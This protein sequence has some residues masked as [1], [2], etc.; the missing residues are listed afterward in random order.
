MAIVCALLFWR[1]HIYPPQGKKNQ[2]N[3]E[4]KIEGF[5]NINLEFPATV[6]RVQEND[7]VYII[8]LNAT[9]PVV[10]MGT[11]NGDGRYY[12]QTGGTRF[13]PVLENMVYIYPAVD[14]YGDKLLVM[15][16]SRRTSNDII[17]YLSVNGI[18]IYLKSDGKLYDF[19]LTTELSTEFQN[20]NESIMQ[21]D[22]RNNTNEIW[23]LSNY[24][25]V[26]TWRVDAPGPVT[27]EYVVVTDKD[28][29]DRIVKICGDILAPDLHMLSQKGKVYVGGDVMP[30][31]EDVIDIRRYA[32]YYMYMKKNYNIYS[33]FSTTPI[34]PSELTPPIV[35]TYNVWTLT[36]INNECVFVYVGNVG[37]GIP[38]LYKVTNTGG[39][40][41]GTGTSIGSDLQIDFVNV[42]SIV[43][44][45]NGDVAFIASTEHICNDTCTAIEYNS[46]GSSICPLCVECPPNQ[47]GDPSNPEGCSNC[48]AQQVRA[49]RGSVC[50]YCPQNTEI[51]P[52]SITPSTPST[53]SPTS[54]CTGC[55]DGYIRMSNSDLPCQP[56]C[57]LYFG[58]VQGIITVNS[59]ASRVTNTDGVIYSNFGKAF[60]LNDLNTHTIN[61]GLH[62]SDYGI[63]PSS[64]TGV[65]G[66]Q[67]FNGDHGIVNEITNTNL[68]KYKKGDVAKQLY[69]G[70]HSNCGVY[71]YSG[72]NISG[73][74][75]K[76]VKSM[77]IESPSSTTTNKMK[78]MGWGHWNRAYHAAEEIQSVCFYDATAPPTDSILGENRCPRSATDQWE[79]GH[80]I[81]CP[82]GLNLINVGNYIYHYCST[83][84]PN[85]SP[86]T[87]G[88][89]CSG[90]VCANVGILHNYKS[91]FSSDCEAQAEC[92]SRGGLY[93]SPDKTCYRKFSGT[94]APCSFDAQCAGGE[95]L[96]RFGK[97]A[98]EDQAYDMCWGKGDCKGGSVYRSSKPKKCKDEH[99]IR[100]ENRDV[101]KATFGNGPSTQ[102]YRN[103]KGLEEKYTRNSKPNATVC[104]S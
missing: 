94:G 30:V 92:I 64:L 19:E 80:D 18:D 17:Q 76:T 2:I 98:N 87:A 11:I 34:V 63:V 65:N 95:I 21:I 1:K 55:P 86:C 59:P 22:Y 97:C 72:Q 53:P 78:H 7:F 91:C 4:K 47:I 42:R 33:S 56:D 32:G 84:L 40:W 48:P 74:W 26:Y 29:D 39:S 73:N 3:I 57:R 16:E 27:E 66:Q 99:Y 5:E 43:T 90:G 49:S 69:V 52:Q 8:D 46:A 45:R 70:G 77:V 23:L 61:E 79:D 9:T 50:T 20:Y 100:W 88:S 89:E 62:S 102:P 51:T 38:T 54:V 75:A 36:L 31:G 104:V 85:N 103:T 93:H 12:R 28:V 35:N 67:V 44:L 15:D 37:A 60:N 14:T 71:V 24:H 101:C 6:G 41:E 68:S 10:T 83:L 25:K 82:E 58:E 13:M 96:C 81:I